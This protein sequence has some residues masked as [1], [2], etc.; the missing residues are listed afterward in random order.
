LDNGHIA[1]L[2]G[3]TKDE[4]PYITEL[5]TAP[6]YDSNVPIKSLPPWFLQYLHRPYFHI[7]CTAL[8]KFDNWTYFA[9]AEWYRRLEQE[10]VRLNNDI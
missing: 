2:V 10:S 5:Y 3:D 8:T 4:V 7:L 1:L 9:E 6:N